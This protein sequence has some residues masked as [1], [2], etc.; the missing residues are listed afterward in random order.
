MIMI[1]TCLLIIF[2]LPTILMANVDSLKQLLPTL[3][4][5]PDRVEVLLDLAYEYDETQMDT[6]LAHAREALKLSRQLENRLLEARS[7]SGIGVIYF[8]SSNNYPQAI[9]YFQQAQQ[10]AETLDNLSF[11]ALNLYRLGVSYARNYN[12]DKALDAFLK[13]LKFYEK[14]DDKAWIA[15]LESQIADI[16]STMQRHQQALEFYRR[17]LTYYRQTHDMEWVGIITNSMGVVYDDIGEYDSAMVYYQR[18]LDIADSLDDQ[19]SVMIALNNLGFLANTLGRYD[20]ALMYYSRALDLAQKLN[21]VTDIGN[22]NTNI[23]HVYLNQKKYRQAQEYLE[24]GLKLSQQTGERIQ[25]QESYELLSRL[26]AERGD[27][28]SALDYYHRYDTLKDS[29]LNAENMRAVAE[30]QMQYET[31]KKEAENKLL[32]QEQIRQEEELRQKE[33]QSYILLSLLILFTLILIYFYRMNRYRTHLTELLKARNKEVQR[34][35]T[36]LNDAITQLKA[37]NKEKDEFLGIVSHDLKNP[38]T[39]ILG[40]TKLVEE[41]KDSFSRDELLSFFPE[42][43]KSG[44]RMFELITNL[45]DIHRLESGR[46]E[47]LPQKFDLNDVVSECI[48]HYR[49]QAAK[50]NIQLYFEAENTGNMVYADKNA[51]RQILDNL[52]SNAVKFSPPHKNVH[53]MLTGDGQVVRCKIRDEGQGLTPEDQKYLF[54]KFARLSAKPTGGEHSTGLGLSIVK[55]LV[56]EMD[57]NVV[58]ESEGKNK[59]ATF[60]VEL[61]KIQD[62]HAQQN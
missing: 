4:P 21:L 6:A 28:K 8:Y 58:A 33:F 1:H 20:E 53:I 24:R 12:Y 34:K 42:I 60:I 37:L 23:G 13:S 14:L 61:P 48:E 50:K 10:L 3:P 49:P 2:F 39:Y 38:L 17:A 16:Y 62:C 57:G 7:L 40:I 54:H 35:N 18:S 56:E 25:I 27:Y 44:N 29:L 9:Y 19:A 22:L 41:H 52:I 11:K 30:L 31:Q 55:K 46:M 59:G 51:T 43:A 47:F 15:E 26:H 45:L 36:E 32:R 5:S